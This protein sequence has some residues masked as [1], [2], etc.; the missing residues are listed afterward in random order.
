MLV[1]KAASLA[2]LGEVAH[3]LALLSGVLG[4]AAVGAAA[5][6]GGRSIGAGADGRSAEVGVRACRARSCASR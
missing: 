1:A 6:L 4:A 2:P 5:P 3:R